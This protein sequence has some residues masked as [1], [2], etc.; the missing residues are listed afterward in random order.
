[1]AD[2]RQMGSAFNRSWSTLAPNVGASAQ[3]GRAGHTRPGR[4][5]AFGQ[6]VQMDLSIKTDPH[7]TE[8]LKRLGR[9]PQHMT[10]QYKRILRKAI[11]RE[12]LP[13]LRKNI[14]KSDRSKK[15]LRSTAGI[16]S[17]N[18][19]R[20]IIGVGGSK[21]FYA[22]IVHAGRSGGKKG[23]VPAVPFFPLTFRQVWVPLNNRLT[24]DMYD[25]LVWLD[26]GIQRRRV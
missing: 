19:N 12:V 1:M 24:R 11:T 10:K 18:L 4:R 17:V 16:M 20:A 13:V 23:T 26:T 22:A 7:F 15:H 5:V 14:P 25:M 8:F 21:N 2:S 6:A 9:M 3:W